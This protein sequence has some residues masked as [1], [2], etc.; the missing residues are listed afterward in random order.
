MIYL[1]IKNRCTIL[2]VFT[3]LFLQAQAQQIPDSILQKAYKELRNGVI[4]YIDKDTILSLQYAEA[5]LYKARKKRD[6]LQIARGYYYKVI[7]HKNVRTK[8]Q[9]YDTIIEI[10]KNLKG[11]NYPTYAFYDKGVIYRRTLQFDTAL[12][13][14]LEALKYNEGSGND[15]IDLLLNLNI[16]EL[17]LRVN[18]NKEALQIFKESWIYVNE[19]DYKNKKADKNT[20]YNILYALANTYR[21]IGDL[22]KAKKYIQLGLSE[23]TIINNDIK[24]HKFVML[25]GA[26][27]TYNEDYLTSEKYL[28][29]AIGEFEDKKA[30]KNTLVSAYYFLAEN[31]KF[32][33]R[34][35][36]AVFYFKKVDSLFRMT[37]DIVPEYTGSYTYLL[38]Y[39]ENKQDINQELMY[40]TRLID[41]DSILSK[42][43]KNLNVEIAYMFDNPKLKREV[44]RIQKDLKL[45]EIRSKVYFY[46]LSGI[47]LLILIVAV[48]QYKKR[49]LY[50]RRFL[51]LVETDDEKEKNNRL[52]ID[53]ISLDIPKETVKEILEK[54]H[55]LEEGID[56][57]NPNLNLNNLATILGTNSSYLSKV[58]NH[59]K[60]KSF[61]SY[62]KKL[63]VNYGFNKLKTDITFRKYTIKAIALECGFKTAESFSKTFY[64]TYGIYPSYFIKQ[65]EK[66]DI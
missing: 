50:K 10:S 39:Y 21:K 16:A 48:Y 47:I 63:R 29:K 30:D 46:I 19:K 9:F 4:K 62:I 33:N 34:P 12:A 35:E 7:N 55:A 36:Q 13:H 6:T 3:F 52:L 49:K 17:K 61:S 56:F 11:E 42:R 18:K 57:T 26:I 25:S 15:H 37:K 1:N 2:G 22:D 54:L 66:S 24:Y 27:A 58:V 45:I 38:K 59:Y 20:Y 40:T 14:F 28:L 44:N 43:Y 64:S 41:V 53:N 51:N 31:Y 23:D 5:Y 32:S 8:L 65:I 60:E